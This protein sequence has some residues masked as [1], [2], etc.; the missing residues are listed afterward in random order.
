MKPL[1]TTV[2]VVLLATLPAGG[3][4]ALV[5]AGVGAGAGVGTYAFV[6]GNATATEKADMDKTWAAA[7]KTVADMEFTVKSTKKDEMQAKLYAERADG[8]DVTITLDRKGQEL[9]EISVRVGVFGDEP[10]SRVIIDSISHNLGETKTA[11]LN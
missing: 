11:S 2:S 9:T 7:Q 5:A 8:K 4:A 6:E 1:F 10:T 3:C